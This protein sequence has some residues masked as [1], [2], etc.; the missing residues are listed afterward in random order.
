[1]GEDA[2]LAAQ[3]AFYA[4]FNGRDL[5]GMEALWARHTPVSCVH[6]GWNLL[7]GRE[8]VLESWQAILQNPSQ[9]RVVDAAERT[10][11]LGEVALVVGRELVAGS[12][13]AATNVF[14]RE[15]GAWKILH[16][17]AS[18]VRLQQ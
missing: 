15:E 13:I 7:S 1:M 17:H 11:V 14:V 16:H 5:K 6:P 10:Q 9:P 12:P 3:S 18:A 4:A 2:V 8:A